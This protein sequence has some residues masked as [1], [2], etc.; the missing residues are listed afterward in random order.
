MGG[1]VDKIYDYSKKAK[2]MVSE[3]Y[4]ESRKKLKEEKKRV[5]EEKRMMDK[6]KMMEESE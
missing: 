3:W 6:K 4:E 1:C 5:M 2:G